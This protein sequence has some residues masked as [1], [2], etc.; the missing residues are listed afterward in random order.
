M[1]YYYQD[2]TNVPSSPPRRQRL[3]SQSLQ[4]SRPLEL[5]APRYHPQP[6]TTDAE[7]LLSPSSHGF[8]GNHVGEQQWMPRNEAW[9]PVDAPEELNTG[10]STGYGWTHGMGEWMTTLE[11][12]NSVPAYPPAIQIHHA[13]DPIFTSIPPVGSHS[14][15]EWLSPTQY[16]GTPQR[17]RSDSV[18]SNGSSVA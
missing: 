16:F 3:T 11:S 10:I 14:Y 13:P 9:T 8:Y 5:S 18:S 15:Q 17:V 1:S 12:I 4:S 7:H 2:D 6:S